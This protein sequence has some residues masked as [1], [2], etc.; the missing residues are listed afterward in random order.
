MSGDI[1]MKTALALSH[2]IE[3]KSGENTEEHAGKVSLQC[4]TNHSEK[5][6][7]LP[8]AHAAFTT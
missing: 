8:A 7:V 5:T 1:A 4:R 6:L 2:S 3:V